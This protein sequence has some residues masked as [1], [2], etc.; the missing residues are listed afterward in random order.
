[1]NINSSTIPRNKKIEIIRAITSGKILP[2]HLQPA[3]IYFFYENMERPG[4]YE[5]PEDLNNIEGK[6]EYN[7][8]E[9]HAF[10][11]QVEQLNNNSLVWHEGK[12]YD[13]NRVI[14]ILNY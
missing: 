6:K 10:I 12:S 8:A 5:G 2:Q 3:K 7:E 11:K 9:Y 4:I 14:T 1:M 13:E